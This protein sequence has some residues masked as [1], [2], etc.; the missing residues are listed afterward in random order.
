LDDV[1]IPDHCIL[2]GQVLNEQVKKVKENIKV[3]VQG[4]LVTG[5]CDGW[6]NIAKTSVV[7]TMMSVENEVG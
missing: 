3:K 7:T 5:K 1:V 6:K 4:K 2:S